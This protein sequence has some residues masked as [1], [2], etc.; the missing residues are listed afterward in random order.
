MSGQ[1]KWVNLAFS[2]V[3]TKYD[4]ASTISI[5]WWRLWIS[6]NATL[7]RKI[8]NKNSL[9]KKTYSCVI[10]LILPSVVDQLAQLALSAAQNS[11][12]QNPNGG[13][14]FSKLVTCKKFYFLS[15]NTSCRQYV[16]VVTWISVGCS[17]SGDVCLFGC[18][19]KFIDKLWL[20]T[21]SWLSASSVVPGL[22]LK[23]TTGEPCP[24]PRPASPPTREP[25]KNK[26]NAS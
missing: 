20:Q 18:Q 9:R 2:H 12:I 16:V 25:Q 10:L 13:N 23:A 6:P 4:S 22:K 11:R 21:F 14:Q 24:Y 17:L 19:S 26:T 15:L 3:V 7:I 1:K 8:L 5:C